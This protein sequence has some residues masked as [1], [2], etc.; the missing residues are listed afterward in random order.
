MYA[1]IKVTGL[2]QDPSLILWNTQQSNS[3]FP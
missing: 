3:E 1:E 2:W